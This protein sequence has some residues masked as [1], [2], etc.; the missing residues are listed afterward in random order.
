MSIIQLELTVLT[1][2]KTQQLTPNKVQK[3]E[4]VVARTIRIMQGTRIA[5]KMY[6]SYL[7][8][9]EYYVFSVRK[10]IREF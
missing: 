10:R 7:H 9:D 8:F 4:T 2:R 1:R 3:T 5:I 6:I